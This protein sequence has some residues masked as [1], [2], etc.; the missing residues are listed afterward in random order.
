MENKMKPGI[1]TTEFWLSAIGTL[2]V[3]IM[4]LFVG[5]GAITSEQADLWIGLIMAATPIAIAIIAAKYSDSRAKVKSS[6]KE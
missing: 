5:Y 6:Y 4:A 3:A 2:V 1:K